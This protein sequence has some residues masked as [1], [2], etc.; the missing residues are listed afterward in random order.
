[1]KEVIV[2]LTSDHIK[3]KG[4]EYVRDY[5][6]GKW[7]IH[8]ARTMVGE[9]G[10]DFFPT[11]YECSVCKLKEQLY[12]INSKP[13]NFCPYCGADMREREGE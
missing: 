13:H 3:I 6:R 5:Q 10:I 11:E 9:L 7:I 1:M 4:G 12:F 8:E 2:K